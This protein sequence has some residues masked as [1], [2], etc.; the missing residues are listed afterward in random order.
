LCSGIVFL[1]IYLNPILTQS[2][3]NSLQNLK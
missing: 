3:I 2:I 1:F